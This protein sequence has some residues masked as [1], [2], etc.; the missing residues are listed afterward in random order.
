MSYILDNYVEGF[1]AHGITLDEF[2]VEAC[3]ELEAGRDVLVSAPTG[4]GKTVAARYA[5]ELALATGKR[6]IYTAP[7]KA[8]SNQKYAD[9]TEELGED[10]VGLLTG[11]FTV[12][13]E[14]PILVVTTEVLR[15]MLF[16]GASDLADTGYAVLDEVHY[17][18]DPDRGPVWEEVILSLP[19][20]VRLV[21]L[22]ATIANTGEL[23]AWMRSVRGDTALVTSNVRPVPLRQCALFGK[24][25]VPVYDA[26]AE[27][28]S[29]ALVAGVKREQERAEQRH[30]A[31]RVGER[32]RRR[33]LRVLGREDMLPAIEFIF[34]R[35]GCDRAVDSLLRHDV[36]LTDAAEQQEIRAEVARVREQL[37]AGDRH[38]IGFDRSA[39]ALERGFGAHHAGVFPAVK[40][41]IERLTARGLVKIVYATGTL[42][43]GIDMPVRTVVLEDLTRW[44]GAGFVNLSATEYTQLIGRAGRRGKDPVGNAVILGGPELD[45]EHLADIGSGRVDPL[46]SVFRPSYN[47]VTNLVL[48]RGYAEARAL[49]ARSFAQFQRNAKIGT[50]NA[51]LER[52][53]RKIAGEERHLHCERGNLVEYV[54]LREKAGHARKAARKAAKRAYRARIEE[55]FAT[56]RTGQVYAYGVGGELEYGLVLSAH[57]KRLRVLTWLGEVVWLELADLS[58]EMRG[59]ASV[60]LP[61]GLSVKRPDV[62]ESVAEEI[63]DA[64]EERVDLGLDEDLLAPWSRF[65]EPDDAAVLAHPVHAC[66][67]LAEHLRVAEGLVSLDHR[68]AELARAADSYADSVGREFDATARVL[69]RRGL[70]LDGSDGTLTGGRGAGVLREL[71]ADADLLLYEALSTVGEEEIEADVFAGWMSLFLSDDRLGSMYPRPRELF[72]LTQRTRK[73]ATELQ[74]VEAEE[75]IERTPDL[76][77]GCADVFAGWVSGWTLDQCIEASRLSAGDFINAA[78]RLVDLLGQ[79][80]AATE[81]TWIAD[82]AAK[83]RDGVRRS[84]LF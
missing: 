54:R 64:V 20:H 70:L 6:C 13:R 11:D 71:H 14:A 7:I 41:L 4:A 30:R 53:R 81:G 27:G 2:Q 66:P 36:V 75:G 21:S 44:D 35:K 8:L 29:R 52:V 49:M 39:R 62:R 82:V 72:R 80:R 23:V 22:S 32:D 79:V 65:A 59:V 45:P 77:P 15:N 73:I 61:T 3:R 76:T 40:E 1:A 18:A 26:D 84:E 78:R 10:A 9:L 17:L 69:E 16:Q 60:S 47:T 46:H 56:A 31:A 19:E 43:L 57:R 37:T 58:S 28:P 83:A 74:A 48:D 55:S 63:T 33:V 25:L 38:A 67:D 5:V 68:A 51:R 24:H 34:S 42:A 50:V 12:N